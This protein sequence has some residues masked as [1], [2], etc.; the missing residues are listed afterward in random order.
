[1]VRVLLVE[2][3]ISEAQKIKSALEKMGHTVTHIIGANDLSGN[4]IVSRSNENIDPANF[5]VAFLDATLDGVY[6]GWHFAPILVD[7]GVLCIAISAGGQFNPMVEK[8]GAQMA[9]PKEEVVPDLRN[10][11]LN[12][13]SIVADHKNRHERSE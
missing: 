1:M 9:M 7:A 13:D 5:D 10:G 2:D 6:H 12:L 3:K 4:N 11:S 8:A